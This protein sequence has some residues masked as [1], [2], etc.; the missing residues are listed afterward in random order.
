MGGRLP[1]MGPAGGSERVRLVV[2]ALAAVLFLAALLYVQLVVKRGLEAP[3][4]EG[5]YVVQGDSPLV[6]APS[7][8]VDPQRLAAV[9]DA[10]RTDRL[11]REPEPYS[12][13]LAEA[14]KLTPGDLE[15]L[16]LRRID[17]QQVLA[18]PAASRGQPFEVKGVLESVEAVQGQLWQEIRG[19]LRDPDGQLYA[20]SVLQEPQVE[21]G[22]VV[23]LRGFFFKLFCLETRPGE[24][25]D[26]VIYLIGRSLVRSFLEMPPVTDL[27]QI[28]F[29][30]ARDYDVTDQV[31]LQEELLYHVLSYVRSLTPEQKEALPAE[32]VTCAGLQHDPGAYRGKLVRV[33]ARYVPGLE[34]PRKLGPGGENPLE[35]QFFQ[36]GILALPGDR[37]VRWVGFDEFPR[38]TLAEGRLVYLTGVFVKVHAW[39]NMRGKILNGP[40]LVPVRFEPF[41]MPD[42]SA[43]HKIGYGIA[44]IT[45]FLMAFFVIAVF[46]DGRKAAQFRREFLRRRRLALERALGARDSAEPLPAPP[47]DA[48]PGP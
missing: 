14:R 35:T 47:A 18:A 48:A 25:S 30:L 36:D 44:G 31:D 2:L 15:A 26:N 10:S 28:P 33:L 41:A 6:R 22:Q 17:A 39:E 29:H 43:Y 45:V 42:V 37:V 7:A 11:V 34:W 38:E 40:L 1:G 4:D 46:R 13:L 9:E 21:V 3:A 16:G 19:S 23:R 27:A 8:K 24:F 12:H 5:E 20:F 32:N